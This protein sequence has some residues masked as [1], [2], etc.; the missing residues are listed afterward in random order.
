MWYVLYNQLH[1]KLEVKIQEKA[2]FIE[3]SNS[4]L[5]ARTFF[6]AQVQTQMYLITD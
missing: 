2:D 3:Y 5:K 1:C 6:I 4:N